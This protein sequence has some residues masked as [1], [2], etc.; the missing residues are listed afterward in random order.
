MQ[1]RDSL[2]IQNHPVLQF[3]KKK[4][5]SFSFEGR[6]LFGYE[7]EPIAVALMDNGIKTLSH[8]KRYGRP[9]GFFCAIGNCCSCLMRVDGTPNTRTCVTALKKG[10]KIEI[11]KMEA[12]A[13]P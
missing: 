11:Q 12:G 3:P 10:M 13:A 4:R 5:V 1:A 7:G 8:S 2:R 9:R 6:T